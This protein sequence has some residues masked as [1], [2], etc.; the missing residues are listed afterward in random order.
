MGI[1][2]TRFKAAVI[3]GD[4]IYFSHSRFNGLFMMDIKSLSTYFIGQFPQSDPCKKDLH[5]VGGC[6]GNWVIFLPGYG[7]SIDLYNI[8]TGEFRSFLLNRY[9]NIGEMACA[10]YIHQN[11]LSIIPHF[12]YPDKFEL[13]F[14]QMN[15]DT[16]EINERWD[17]NDKIK[18]MLALYEET[19]IMSTS[20]QNGILWFPIHKSSKV[21]KFDLENEQIDVIE[22]E[23]KDLNSISVIGKRIWLTQCSGSIYSWNAETNETIKY[24]NQCGETCG[25]AVKSIIE[26]GKG[27]YALPEFSEYITYLDFN[28]TDKGFVKLNDVDIMF[29]SKSNFENYGFYDGKFIVYPYNTSGLYEIVSLSNNIQCRQLNSKIHFKTRNEDWL[30]DTILRTQYVENQGYTIKEFC[31]DVEKM[32]SE[33]IKRDS[34]NTRTVGAIIYEYNW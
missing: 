16:F 7:N 30:L 25:R 15:L 12:L 31:T 14:L 28:D 22:T 26:T 9:Q 21:I 1:L 20:C 4:N 18:K 27:A 13:P 6:Y 3:V 2:D 32:N 34:K 11:R 23:I 8:K 33:K 17:I 19:A 24:E 5:S 29:R 10:G